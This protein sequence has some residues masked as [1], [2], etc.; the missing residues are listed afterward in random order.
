M[1]VTS[2]SGL[3]T[4]LQQIVTALCQSSVTITKLLDPGTGFYAAA[5]GWQFSASAKF[6]SPSGSNFTWVLPSAGSGTQSVFGATGSN[7]T[8]TFQL[9]PNTGTGTSSITIYESQQAGYSFVSVTCLKTSGDGT[10]TTTTGNPFTISNIAV[11]A[12][13]T[14]EVKNRLVVT[15][16]LTLLKTA[17]PTNYTAVGQVIHYTYKLTNDGNVNLQPPYNVVDNKTSVTCPSTPSVLTPGASITC[18]ATYIITQADMHNGSVINLAQATAKDMS[19]VTVISNQDSE[20]VTGPPPTPTPIPT[21]VP[22]ATATPV[23][24]SNDDTIDSDFDPGTGRAPAIITNANN[25]TVDGGFVLPETGP[26]SAIINLNDLMNS[27][28]EVSLI[29]TSGNTWTYRVRKITGRDLSYWSLGVVNCMNNIES[30]SPTSTYTSGTDASTGFVGVKWTVAPGFTDGTFSITLDGS[31]QARPTQALVKADT[32]S[33]QVSISGPDCDVPNVETPDDT[34][35]DGGTDGSDGGEGESCSFGWVDWNGGGNSYIE[36]ANY[37]ANLELSGVRSLNEV[38]ASGPEVAY[39]SAVAAQLDAVKSSGE[40]I[41]IP[42]TN[43]STGAICGFANVK[44]LD[45]ELEEGASWLNL[46][47]LQT[48]I[49]GTVT[50]PDAPDYGARDVRMKK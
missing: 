15:P 40:T 6:P 2:F 8:L 29:G 30:Y 18:A 42:L 7:G 37:M 41:K 46:Q 5:S 20:V 34:E 33:A 44:L 49:H 9:K 16:K 25:P 22:V 4:T 47:F 28:Y 1:V 17:S 45:Y 38:L 11:N 26:Q 31:Y 23:P 48:L 24:Q 12:I 21:L 10:I 27:Q 32:V 50:D 35:G 14:C 43:S 36:L 3:A 39:D 13:V 19:N